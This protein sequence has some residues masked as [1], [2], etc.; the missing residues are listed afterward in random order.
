LLRGLDFK[1]WPRNSMDESA[2]WKLEPPAAALIDEKLSSGGFTDP[3][4]RVSGG[5]ELERSQ[6]INIVYQSH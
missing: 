1:P 5:E 6:V 4:V 3:L 2:S